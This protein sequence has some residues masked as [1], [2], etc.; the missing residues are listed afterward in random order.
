[1]TLFAA[2]AGPKWTV[3]VVGTNGGSNKA[4]LTGL[5]DPQRFPA[6][7]TATITTT[8]RDI[9]HPIF[10]RLLRKQANL[11]PIFIAISCLR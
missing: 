7:P 3:F 11:F 6:Q 4:P 2:T 8:D 1:M 10:A 9:A 5:T